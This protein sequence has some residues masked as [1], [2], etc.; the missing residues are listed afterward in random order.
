MDGRPPATVEGLSLAARPPVM[1]ERLQLDAGGTSLVNGSGSAA[2]GSGGEPV[3]ASSAE[4]A[5]VEADLVEGATEAAVEAGAAVPDLAAEGGEEGAACGREEGLSRASSASSDMGWASVLG[6]AAAAATASP[7]GSPSA[8]CGSADAAASSQAAASSAC[9]VGF[10][11]E[12]ASS[13]HRNWWPPSPPSL[14]AARPVAV[15]PGDAAAA[16][17]GNAAAPPVQLS[18]RLERQALTDPEAAML[19]DWCCR[20]RGAADVRK[21]WLFDNRLTDGGAEAV[22]RILAAHPG[23]Q[24]VGR[25]GGLV[26]SSRHVP[27]PLRDRQPA[28]L[29]CKPR[30]FPFVRPGHPA[31]GPQ[32]PCAPAR[33]PACSSGP[34]LAQHADAARRGCAAGGLAGGAVSPRGRCHRAGRCR[35][36]A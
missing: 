15:D 14:A 29:P 2:E 17:V 26:L 32:R 11:G 22:A 4:V 27:A 30:R 31:G 12:A 35:A 21:L 3:K 24:E 9:D 6:A 18:I 20:Q 33:C 5:G 23:M 13:Q 8:S 10:P 7:G 16:A 25:A 19:A 36:S 1:A 28:G 34:S